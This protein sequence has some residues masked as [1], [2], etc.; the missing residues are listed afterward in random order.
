MCMVDFINT[1]GLRVRSPDETHLPRRKSLTAQGW[2]VAWEG[3]CLL[4]FEFPT[5]MRGSTHQVDQ[6]AEVFLNLL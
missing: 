6:I 3:K 5:S 1:N 2:G 4:C